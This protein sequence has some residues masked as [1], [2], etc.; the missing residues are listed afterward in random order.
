[1]CFLEISPEAPP[2]RVRGV[3]L[4]GSVGDGPV[5]GEWVS[6]GRIRGWITIGSWVRGRGS[7][8]LGMGGWCGVLGRRVRTRWGW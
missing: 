5:G 8:G 7:V 1:M 3:P 6:G 4:V 2:G